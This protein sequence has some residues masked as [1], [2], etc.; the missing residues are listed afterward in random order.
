MPWH[1]FIDSQRSGKILLIYGL[2]V[3]TSG[4]YNI[5]SCELIVN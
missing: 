2:E 1:T 4:I 3:Q 5:Q